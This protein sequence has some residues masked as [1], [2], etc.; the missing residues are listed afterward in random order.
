MPS[1]SRSP[2][3]SLLRRAAATCGLAVAGALIGCSDAVAPST[4][5]GS[6]PSLA[7]AA[8]SVVVKIAGL[9]PLVG[10]TAN[11]SSAADINDLGKVVGMSQSTSSNDQV[12]VV[13]EGSAFP[14][15]L[16]D[17]PNGEG[18]SVAHAIN[19]GGTIVGQVLAGAIDPATRWLKVN[20]AWTVFDLGVPEGQ[21]LSEAFDVTD[22]GRIV[23]WSWSQTSVQG[24]LWQNGI[25]TSLAGVA[26]AYALNGSGQVVGQS[27]VIRAVLWTASGGVK[28]LGAL[29]GSISSA[30]GLNANGDVVGWAQTSSGDMHAFLWTAKRGMQ[31]LGTLGGAT[32]EAFGISATGQI[33]GRSTTASGDMHAALWIKGKIVDLGVLPGYTR[34]EAVAINNKGQIVGTSYVADDARATV[35][36]I[37]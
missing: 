12:A 25:M 19:S 14:T 18:S 5:A 24:F 4:P 29:G 32:S 31:D 11:W 8:P 35:W 7:A 6:A 22:D 15:A 34:S 30:R 3:R 1:T 36:T 2:I 10:A 23:G 21:Q 17:L 26:I 33:V 27:D 28:D 9:E 37:K 13:W 20:G 16:P